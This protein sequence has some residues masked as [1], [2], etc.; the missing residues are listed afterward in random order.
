M[1]PI[2]CASADSGS[3]LF[4]RNTFVHILQFPFNYHI[5][6]L[7]FVPHTCVRHFHVQS[8]VITDSYISIDVPRSG[9]YAYVDDAYYIYVHV[10]PYVYIGVEYTM[11]KHTERDPIT[12]QIPMYT[13]TCVLP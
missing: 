3:W 12:E 9:V 7:A 10:Y 13:M 4:S 8:Q 1:P 5:G 2:N 11:E 6:L